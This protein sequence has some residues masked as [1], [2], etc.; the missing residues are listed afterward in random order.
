MLNLL[1]S[2]FSETIL[3]TDANGYYLSLFLFSHSVVYLVI[4]F[5][6]CIGTARGILK[7]VDIFPGRPT[8]RMLFVIAGCVRHPFSIALLA[9]NAFFFLV[10][11]RQDITSAIIAVVL[12]LLL[13]LCILVLASVVFLLLER[14]RTSAG[15][16]LVLVLLFFIAGLAGSIVF[17][18]ESFL[19]YVPLVSSC[20]NGIQAALRQDYVQ[21]AIQAMIL[22]GI[23]TIILMA[24]KRFA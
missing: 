22:V 13:M 2:G 24:V 20:V 9:S 11:Y 21:T 18:E 4:I 3:R 1:P 10:L 12:Y 16:A 19:A 23:P 8:G 14:R 6:Y 17:H 5:S 15:I 7:N